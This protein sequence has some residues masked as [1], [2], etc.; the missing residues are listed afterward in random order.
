MIANKDLLPVFE[1]LE[2]GVLTTIQDLGR[3]GCQKYGVPVSGAMDDFSL[4]LANLLVGNDSNAAALE[5]TGLG[6]KLKVLNDAVVSLNG[7]DFNA[8]LDEN[9]FRGWRLVRVRKGSIIWIKEARRGFR[10]YLAV[11][12]GIEVP[13]V[14]GSRSTYLTGKMG[15]LDGRSLRKGDIIN[16]SCLPVSP[17]RMPSR[18]L[19]EEY[20]P[21]FSSRVEVRVIMG[22][23]DDRFDDEGIKTFLNS[24]YAVSLNSD[25]TAYRLVGPKIAHR[26]KADIITDAI[27]QG[28]VQVPGDGQPIV[29]MADRPTTGGYAKIAC[30]IGPDIPK[31]AQLKPEDEVRFRKIGIDEAHGLLRDKE[32]ELTRIRELL[33]TQTKILTRKKYRVR[34]EDEIYQVVV[35]EIPP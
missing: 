33:E 29:M 31:I 23:Q 1:I 26:Q 5:I 24:W 9:P 30:V 4:K 19:P 20:I 16:S 35:E 12:G 22:P 8:A 27:P 14:L 7:A 25:R 18:F 32:A 21:V 3:F 17:A 11:A 13:E 2:P 15:G 28:A 10:G 6:P 34:V